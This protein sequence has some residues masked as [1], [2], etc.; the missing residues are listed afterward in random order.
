MKFAL[1]VE[2][3]LL[4]TLVFFC[5]SMT[6][7]RQLQQEGVDITVRIFPDSEHGMWSLT[8]E[9]QITTGYF[10]LLADYVKGEPLQQSY[11]QSR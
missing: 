4:A 1:A 9:N 7:L 10:D 11:G 3:K 8:N 2:V 6:R 5:A